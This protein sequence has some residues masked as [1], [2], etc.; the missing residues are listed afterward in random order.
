MEGKVLRPKL[1][2][3]NSRSVSAWY[4]ATR[5]WEPFMLS[6]R[7]AKSGSK[8]CVWVGASWFFPLTQGTSAVCATGRTSE[9][10]RLCHRWLKTLA[11]MW[12][13]D[14]ELHIQTAVHAVLGGGGVGG[15]ALESGAGIRPHLAELAPGRIQHG[16]RALVA[17]ASRNVAHLLCAYCLHLTPLPQVPACG[18]SCRNQ[19]MSNLAW[20]AGGMSHV[21]WAGWPKFSEYKT[22]VTEQSARAAMAQS[23]KSRHRTLTRV[24]G[25]EHSHTHH[26]L[27]PL[28]LCIAR[29]GPGHL[30]SQASFW[31]HHAGPHLSAGWPASP[32][33]SPLATLPEC[34]PHSLAAAS[35]H[36][37]RPSRSAWGHDDEQSRIVEAGRTS[38]K[39]VTHT[40]ATLV[41][42]DE[43]PLLGPTAFMNKI[44]SLTDTDTVSLIGNDAALVALWAQ[45]AARRC[46]PGSEQGP[47]PQDHAAPHTWLGSTGRVHGSQPIDT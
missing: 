37:Q 47:S 13:L 35:S 26:C 9:G 39:A 45:W 23:T 5:T 27:R 21:R 36:H 43:G 3:A 32:L 22:S 4:L 38:M 12:T 20:W 1:A 44:P 24:G 6:P 11:Q 28:R 33:P 8:A 14:A 17:S 41:L 30:A 15:A 42:R 16:N 34:R 2:L 10:V 46:T 19:G 31:E 25:I 40:S 18:K 29:H 7:A